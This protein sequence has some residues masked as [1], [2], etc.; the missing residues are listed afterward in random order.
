MSNLN[1]SQLAKRLN[2]G[3]STL[4]T[5]QREFADWLT[6]ESGEFGKSNRRITYNEHDQLVM[7]VI[8]AGRNAHKTFE[9][10]KETLSRDL[11][12]AT[13]DHDTESILGETAGETG[14]T[15]AGQL[16]TYQQATL[17]I[18][19]LQAVEASLTAVAEE[20]DRLLDQLA[21]AQETTVKTSERAAAAESQVNMLR[22]QVGELKAE[23][24]RRVELE[25][26]VARLQTE[27]KALTAAAE[28]EETDV[29]RRNL[30][31]RLAQLF[32]R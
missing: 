31:N 6:V 17:L 14:E 4:R 23:R 29:K 3:V 21:D 16:I 32:G 9:Q 7:S 15:A 18:G 22:D 2:V 1:R 8:A 19:K 20:R 12:T 27:L 28:S 30:L 5:W 25:R 26:E 11:E 13:V 24:E 10:I